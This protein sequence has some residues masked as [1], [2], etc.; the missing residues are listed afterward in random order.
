MENRKIKYVIAPEGCCRYLTPG[1]RYEVENHKLKDVFT[2]VTDT[3]LPFIFRIEK[4]YH[5][6]GQS[7]IVVY[8]DE[9]F[10]KKATVGQIIAWFILALL[11][12]LTFLYMMQHR[13]NFQELVP[14]YTDDDGSTL[15][16]ER[17]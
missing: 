14:E 4:C 1:K 13:T 17:P 8:E 7:W 6:N 5:L 2:S 15:F 3:G 9:P 16:I 11:T 12:L 10:T